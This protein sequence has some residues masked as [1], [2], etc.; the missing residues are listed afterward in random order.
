[1]VAI[2]GVNKWINK[3]KY[4]NTTYVDLVVFLSSSGSFSTDLKT[5]PFSA[6]SC[7]GA[8]EDEDA[9]GAIGANIEEIFRIF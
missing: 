1:M 5:F 9:K 4:V 6:I 8:M 7:I 2:V 3:Y